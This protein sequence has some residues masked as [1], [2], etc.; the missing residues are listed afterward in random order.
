MA[1]SSTM[2]RMP[3]PFLTL[4]L[5]I[6]ALA[7]TL[8]SPVAGSMT[9]SDDALQNIPSPGDDFDIKS[10]KLL[11]PILIPRVPGTDGQLRA[12]KHFVDFF[13]ENLPEWKLEWQNSTSKTPV[14]GN[15]DV[16]FSNLIFRR[17]PPW[18]QNGDVSRLTLV[19]HYDS[20]YEPHGFIGAIDSA[21]PC[22]MLMHVARSIE[23]ALK[24]KWNKMQEDGDDGLDDAQ[25]IQIIFLD[26]EEAF[27]DWSNDDSLYGARSLAEEWEFQ[28]HGATST[29]RT[30]LDSISLFLLLDLLGSKN[31][32]IPSYFLTTHWAYRAMAG[33]EKRMRELGVLETKPKRPF[34]PEANKAS[35]R[36]SHSYIDDDHRPFMQR[37]VEI[38]HII[39]TPFPDVW[40][41][42]TDDGEHLDLPTVRDWARLT[43]AF[44]VDW[45]GIQDF[46]PKL[47]GT[48]AKRN[49]AAGTTT[50]SRRTEL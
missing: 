43:T 13:R 27:K 38:L 32:R 21:A 19:A 30:P 36:F 29:Y 15:K 3:S 20:K 28:F 6:L 1:T 31:P 9:L 33:L 45:M 4:A 47:A 50:S 11:A 16:P 49:A 37:G 10:G 12:Q 42:M 26:G 40:H 17:D 14:S 23:D 34:L 2:P 24:A 41:E 7:S 25:G 18:A 39:P 35:H 48:K 44:T 8:L 5:C 46:M 22:A